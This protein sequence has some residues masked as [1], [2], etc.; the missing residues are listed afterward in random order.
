MKFAD[1]YTKVFQYLL[2]S[3]FTIAVVLTFITFL[4]AFIF[5]KDVNTASADYVFELIEF[6]E[7]GLWTNG[8]MVFAMQMMLMLVL[9]HILALTP[10]V[11]KGIS[12]I[13]QFANNTANAAL[14]VSFFTILVAFFNWGLGLIFGAIFAR[15]IAEHALRNNIKINYPLIGAAGYVGLMVWHGGIS[16]S[17]L[18]KVAEPGHLADM[19]EGILSADRIQ[20]LPN[21]IDF[22][23][24]VFSSMNI[25]SAALILLILPM[26]FFLIGKKS[27]N[28]QVPQ[29]NIKMNE[30]YRETKNYE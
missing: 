2:P 26:V 15:K 18:T 21:Q 5:T 16:G 17:S 10:A 6:W 25:F 3:P 1:K 11:E 27:S 23:Q 29:L 4:V 7:N 22:S 9:G 8:L 12:F 24:T 30:T 28:D 14:L 13:T 20:A 19:M